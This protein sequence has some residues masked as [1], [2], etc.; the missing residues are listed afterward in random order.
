MQLLL[1]THIWLWSFREPHRLTPEVHQ[2]IADP[3]N[4]RFLSPVSIWEAIILLEKKKIEIK[5][6]FGEWFEQ[7]RAE[8]ELK[9]APFDWKVVHEMRLIMLGYKDPGDRFLAA[10]A[11]AY[12]LTLVTADKRLLCVP[13]LKTL[14]NI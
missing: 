1:D 4:D 10:T 13:G 2:V 6:D 9:E 11:K 5:S 12:D 14:G 3:R 8:L 7:T